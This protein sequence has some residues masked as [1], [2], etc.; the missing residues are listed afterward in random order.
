MGPTS[1]VTVP[2][3]LPALTTVS[4]TAIRNVALTVT[5]CPDVTL[6]RHKLP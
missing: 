4:L 2:V 6:R 5:G 1:L 3:P